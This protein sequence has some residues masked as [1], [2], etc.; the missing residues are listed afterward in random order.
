MPDL[1]VKMS[2]I[3]KSFG[4][5]LVLKDVDFELEKGTVHALL[6]ENG[7]GKSTLM[8]ILSGVLSRDSGEIIFDGKKFENSGAMSLNPEIAFIHQELAL[9]N[10]L[11]ITENIFLGCEIRKGALIDKKK[12]RAATEELLKQIGAELSP[13]TLVKNLNASCKQIIEIA[14]AMRKNA[15][16]IIM[17]EP[18]ASL[19]NAEIENVFKIMRSVKERGISII[20]ISHKLNEIFEICDSFTIIKDGVLVATGAVTPE[21]TDKEITRYMVGKDLNYDS[22]YQKREVRDAILEFKNLNHEKYFHNINLNVMR[23]EVV[24]I[25]GLLGDGRSEAVSTIYGSIRKYDGAVLYCGKEVHFKSAS[26][27]KKYGITYVPPNRKENG[28]VKDLSIEE[29]ITLPILQDLRRGPMISKEKSNSVCE[30]YINKLRI[31]LDR[32]ESLITSL[33]GGN[34]QK[35][36]FA[37]ALSSNPTLV[38]LENP[39][40]GVDVGAKL[41]IYQLI[42][43][44]AKEGISF[45]VLSGE[46]SELMKVCDRIYVMSKG[47]IVKEFDRSEVTEEILMVT[48]ASAC[49]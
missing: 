30:K 43:E 48:A 42:M 33:S 24:G 6:G 49:N 32:K 18:T 25:T 45:L 29:N 28:I 8:N 35:T 23:G 46:A 26:H 21:L 40:Q 19:T 9:I 22:L 31:K 2:G 37:K 39:T 36:V 38:I 44:L 17:D 47:S 3:R 13:D 5:N 4:G 10:D 16:V 12:M 15:K 27:A 41:E 14:K 11:D 34:Q 1:I 20:F 7:S